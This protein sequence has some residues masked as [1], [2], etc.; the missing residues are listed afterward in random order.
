MALFFCIF[1]NLFIPMSNYKKNEKRFQKAAKAARQITGN[2]K[3]EDGELLLEAGI[4]GHGFVFCYLPAGRAFV[5]ICCGTKA[6]IIDE[7]ENEFGRIL[8]Y[9]FDGNIVEIEKE[10]LIITGYD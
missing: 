1:E 10:K 2:I 6:I 7:E 5:K 9:T 3:E 4:D 8:I